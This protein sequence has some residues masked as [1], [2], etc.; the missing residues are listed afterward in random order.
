MN[1]KISSVSK[2]VKKYSKEI[3]EYEEWCDNPK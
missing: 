3:S 1:E 2:N